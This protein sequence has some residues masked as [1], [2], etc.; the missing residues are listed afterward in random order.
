MKTFRTLDDVNVSNKRVLLRLDLNSPIEKG[1][2][3]L[4]P[5]LIK[6]SKTIKELSKK[7]AKTCIIA[8]QGRPGG[9]DF[10]D[11]KQHARLLSNETGLNV[12][13]VDDIYGDKALNAINKLK[14]KEVILLKNIRSCSEEFSNARNNKLLKTLSKVFDIFVQDALSILHREHASII[15]FPKRLPSYIGRI[16][17]EEI[18]ALKKLNVKNAVYVLGG[19]KPSDHLDL[20]KYVL[21][22]D[23]AKR[24][25]TTGVLGE[26]FL[27]AKGIDLGK[28]TEY[29]DELV[30]SK[31]IPE[32]KKLI[33]KYPKKIETPIDSAIKDKKRIEITLKDLP[34]RKNMFD[35][36][37]NTIKNYKK[38][39]ENSNTVFMKGTPGK[40][41]DKE[42]MLGTKEILKAVSKAKFSFVGGGD[43]TTAMRMLN[44]SERKYSYVSLSGG[45]LLMYLAGKKLPGLEVLK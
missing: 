2:V 34:S 18:N 32:L 36:G 22:E 33:K 45:A 5:R 39:I 35:I 42:F 38:I 16:L 7:N 23:K 11:L 3:K 24:I 40:Y 9:E 43:T 26:A 28:K 14:N 41:L 29:I 20:L 25:L 30:E 12:K 13:Y 6:H 4:S 31:V 37:K 21:K 1:K 17:E 19:A 8:H 44:I 10:F 15:G 27:I